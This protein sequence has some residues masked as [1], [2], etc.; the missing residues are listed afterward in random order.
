VP[1][2]AADGVPDSSPLLALKV[3]HDGLLAI[4]KARARPWESV[5]DGV[6]A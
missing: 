2:L 1:T 4:A 6:N 5:A 3:A